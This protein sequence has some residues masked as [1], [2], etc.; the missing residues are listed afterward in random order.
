MQTLRIRRQLI[1]L[2][3]AITV[4]LAEAAEPRGFVWKATRGAGVVYLAG[5][6]HMLTPDFYPL[7][8]AFDRAFTDSDL[9]VE[10]VEFSEMTAPEMQMKT[11]MRAMLPS[12]QSLDKVL[13]PATLALVNKTAADVGAPVEALQRLK[14]WM[15]AL[16]L[17]GLELHKAGFDPELGIDKHFYDAALV[18]KKHVQGLETLAFQI[19]RFDEM[20]MDLQDRLLAETLK[21][22]ETT[23][24]EFTRLADAWQAGDLPVVERIA[25][26]DLR[27]EPAMY[28]RLLVE[29]NK[30]WLPKLDALFARKGR[31]MVVVGAA[32]LVGPDGLLAMF[33]A[34]GYRVDQL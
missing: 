12:G 23:K 8:P 18:A 16:S 9:L 33:K 27:S 4:G 25:L 5:S 7:H 2:A 22:L 24:D 13:S 14:P 21:E 34:K 15:I 10:E 6:I 28:Q 19:S 32:H 30:N 1:V 20:P 17:E 3:L 11:L 31:T 29:R 26:E